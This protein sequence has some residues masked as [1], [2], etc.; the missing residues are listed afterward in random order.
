M[1]APYLKLYNLDRT[2]EFDITRYIL[3]GGL[4]IE[5][6]DLDTDKSGRE[7]LTGKMVRER[8]AKK[9]TITVKL[10][11]TDDVTISHIYNILFGGGN[12]EPFCRVAYVSPCSREAHTAED[13]PT[14][15]C[16]SFNY[17]AQRYN[18][19]T[20]SIFY[21]GATFKLIQK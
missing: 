18:R 10:R 5:H 12:K 3:D 15:Y 20:D 17:G 11:R 6:E 2:G 4:T 7:P 13:A 8:I 14:Y 21:D 19:R 16:S 9:H 1:A